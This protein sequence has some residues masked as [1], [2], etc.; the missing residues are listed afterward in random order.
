MSMPWR[1]TIATCSVSSCRWRQR[2]RNVCARAGP[3]SGVRWRFNRNFAKPTSVSVAPVDLRALAE[4][5]ADEVRGEARAHGGSI[6]V[7]GNFPVI[8]GDDVLL[9]QAFSNLVR[10]AVEASLGAARAPQVVIEGQM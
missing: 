10:N 1:R 7:R 3:S 9:R 5:A 2:S 8:E 6:T 4:R